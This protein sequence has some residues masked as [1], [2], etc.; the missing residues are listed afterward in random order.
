MILGLIKS[1]INASMRRLGYSV[2]RT[3]ND[4]RRTSKI[5]ESA[6][7][8][9]IIDVGSHVGNTVKNFRAAYPDALILAIEPVPDSFR[10]LA[11]RFAEDDLVEC[12]NAA[13]SDF[14][15]RAEI[16]VPKKQ[17][18]TAS[19]KRPA[20]GGAFDFGAWDVAEIQTERLDDIYE[21]SSIG[22]ALLLKIDV[23]GHEMGVLKGAPVVLSRTR[24]IVCEVSLSSLYEAQSSAG[25]ILT[26]LESSGFRLHGILD[27]YTPRNSTEPLYIDMVF[28]SND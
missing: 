3:E 1:A 10:L 17:H 20:E 14:N 27:Q 2:I 11:A 24:F 13:A 9:G 21:R 28:I 23:Q 19:L 16:H 4:F 7:L 15:G 6:S 5:F 12:V 22:D 26:F 8:S 18:S 25:E